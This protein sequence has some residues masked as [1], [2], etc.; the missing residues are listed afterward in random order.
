MIIAFVLNLV[1]S[2]IDEKI[3]N[4]DKIKY[5]SFDIIHALVI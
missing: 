4:I 3:K 5:A 2:A 1:P